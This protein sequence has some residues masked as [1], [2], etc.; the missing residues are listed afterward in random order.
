M[1]SLG[2]PPVRDALCAPSST[3]WH[4][5]RSEPAQGVGVSEQYGTLHRRNYPVVDFQRPPHE[6]PIFMFQPQQM[7]KFM[8]DTFIKIYVSLAHPRDC[9]YPVMFPS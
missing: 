6:R 8:V 4:Y 1:A 7:A 3:A 9:R 5:R 2:S